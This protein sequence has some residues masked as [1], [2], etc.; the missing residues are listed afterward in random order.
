MRSRNGDGPVK[1]ALVRLLDG[2][3]SFLERTDYMLR[4]GV[5]DLPRR[6]RTLKDHGQDSIEYL[7]SNLAEYTENLSNKRLLLL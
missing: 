7:L 6:R 3:S 2:L 1:T 5:P 4:N